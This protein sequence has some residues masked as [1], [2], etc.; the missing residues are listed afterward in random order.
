M[1][2]DTGK[3]QQ[4]SLAGAVSEMTYVWTDLFAALAPRVRSAPQPP[5]ARGTKRQRNEDSKQDRPQPKRAAAKQAAGSKSSKITPS[6]WPFNWSRQ[7]AGTGVCVRYHALR[8]RNKKF[9][10]SRKCPILA[11]DGSP[12]GQTIRHFA[13]GGAALTKWLI[14]V[15]L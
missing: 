3:E 4:W 5:E 11:A 6:K 14:R 13:R 7:V 2:A 1:K 12:Y 15:A 9:R 10:C 8:C